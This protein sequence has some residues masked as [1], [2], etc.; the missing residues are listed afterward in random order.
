MPKTTKA[1]RLDFTINRTSQQNVER[2]ADAMRELLADDPCVLA[3]T[4]DY[5]RQMWNCTTLHPTDVLVRMVAS[6]ANEL[7]V[8]AVKDCAAGVLFAAVRS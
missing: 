7:K 8:N 1:A 6:R 5:I 4:I 3:G 2:I